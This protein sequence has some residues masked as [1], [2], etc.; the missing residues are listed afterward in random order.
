MKPKYILIKL[1]MRDDLFVI[2]RLSGGSAGGG[3]TITKY[4]IVYPKDV[5]S[6]HKR[7]LNYELRG[8]RPGEGTIF[9]PK[10]FH[11]SLN[12]IIKEVFNDRI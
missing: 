5:G 4:E 3:K 8:N 12:G 2:K 6:W 10:K 1:R 11:D 9:N 7:V